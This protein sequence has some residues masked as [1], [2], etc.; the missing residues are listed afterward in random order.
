[1]KQLNLQASIIKTDNDMFI[2]KTTITDFDGVLQWDEI[3]ATSD[4][5][6]A[7]AIINRYTESIKE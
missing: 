7:K 2:V 1:M 5:D 4:L 6:I 3:N